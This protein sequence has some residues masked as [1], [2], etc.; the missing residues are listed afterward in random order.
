MNLKKSFTIIIVTLILLSF[1][2]SLLLAYCREKMIPFAILGRILLSLVPL[3]LFYLL[4]KMGKE[5]PKQ[6]SHLSDFEKS[7]IVEGEIVEDK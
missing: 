3:A 1:L 2:A 6:K 7:R 5:Q 4:R